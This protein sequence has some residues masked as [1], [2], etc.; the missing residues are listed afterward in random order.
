MAKPT[1]L[2]QLITEFIDLAKAYLRQETVEPAKQLGRFVGLSLAAGIV[3]TIGAIFL[4]IAGLRWVLS[5]LPSG[6]NWQAVG[7]LIAAVALGV[8]SALII[9]AGSSSSEKGR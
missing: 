9:W 3:F 8:V 6:P 4:T 1:E 2:P 5:A 7:Y